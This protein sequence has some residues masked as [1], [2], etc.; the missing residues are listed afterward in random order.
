[1]I[2][3]TLNYGI[4]L[5]RHHDLVKCD[6]DDDNDDGDDPVY[7]DLAMLKAMSCHDDH[8]DDHVTKTC[9]RWLPKTCADYVRTCR[10]R[11]KVRGTRDGL[12]GGLPSKM[13]GC[14]RIF[15]DR[16]ETCVAALDLQG[17]SRS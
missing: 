13:R 9:Q 6:A 3:L 4:V 17:S 7:D 16:H 12:L 8:D 15:G 14:H 1:M 2:S 5:A 11:W 10:Q